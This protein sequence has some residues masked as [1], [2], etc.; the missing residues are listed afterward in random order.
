VRCV[1]SAYVRLS[2][3]KIRLESPTYE[4]LRDFQKAFE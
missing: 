3:L 1:I 4:N 2:T